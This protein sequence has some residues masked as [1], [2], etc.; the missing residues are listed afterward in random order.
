MFSDQPRPF[1]KTDGTSRFAARDIKLIRP[2]GSLHWAY[3][4]K[5]QCPLESPSPGVRS[6]DTSGTGWG[7]AGKRGR[8]DRVLG[9]DKGSCC[10]SRRSA[11]K[12]VPCVALP[13]CGTRATCSMAQHI[14]VDGSIGKTRTWY[15][16]RLY[17][18]HSASQF[19]RNATE[20]TR[21]AVAGHLYRRED[22]C[23]SA[24]G[25]AIVGYCILE[26]KGTTSP[27]DSIYV[28]FS[29]RPCTQ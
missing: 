15:R 23:R 28:T 3:R 19:R 21:N 12:T 16:G 17:F 9:G 4:S 13:T 22:S 6:I 24:V 20:A 26:A 7:S 25:D 29:S 5:S 18:F 8:G 2:A 11:G 10:L 1:T 14:R 27:F